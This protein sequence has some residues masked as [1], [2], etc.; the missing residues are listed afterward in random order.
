MKNNPEM[1]PEPARRAFT[2][3][4]KDQKLVKLTK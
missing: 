3:E 2:K 4:E 1:L